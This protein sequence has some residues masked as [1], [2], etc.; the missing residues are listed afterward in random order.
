MALLLGAKEISQGGSPARKRD[1]DAW[2]AYN[3]PFVTETS[4]RNPLSFE[5]TYFLQPLM[6]L[7]IRNVEI[8][9]RS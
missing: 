1:T 3:F 9:D 6:P 2:L 8:Q 4:S 7:K 5:R